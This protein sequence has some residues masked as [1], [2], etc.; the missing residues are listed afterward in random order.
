MKTRLGLR[1][2]KI[3]FESLINLYNLMEKG[4]NEMNKDNTFNMQ[5]SYYDDVWTGIF[6]SI[7]LSKKIE[8]KSIGRLIINTSRPMI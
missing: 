2:A 5:H 3:I 4:K 1:L 7:L 6:N 8:G